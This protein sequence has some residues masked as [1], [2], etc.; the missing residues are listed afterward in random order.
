MLGPLALGRLL[1]ASLALGVVRR[2]SGARWPARAGAAWPG[3][4]GSGLLWFGV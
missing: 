2:L 1:V 4:L 3:I